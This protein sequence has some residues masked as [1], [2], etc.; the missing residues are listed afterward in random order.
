MENDYN[1]IT[2]KDIRIVFGEARRNTM[3]VALEKMRIVLFTY[4]R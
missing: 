1:L 2:V 4:C 3:D